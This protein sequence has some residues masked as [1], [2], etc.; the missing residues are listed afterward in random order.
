MI[1]LVIFRGNDSGSESIGSVY[2]IFTFVK[3]PECFKE[4]GKETCCEN[5][6]SVFSRMSGFI[7]HFTEVNQE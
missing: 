6:A 1:N 5:S 3:A 2:K 7:F 4:S